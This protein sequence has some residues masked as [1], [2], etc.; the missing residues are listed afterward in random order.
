M[1]PTDDDETTTP[2]PGAAPT[3]DDDFVS[4]TIHTS[5]DEDE[6]HSD[7]LAAGDVIGEY[8]VK[9][10]IGWGG[11]STVYSAV[12][13]RK[14]VRVAVKVMHPGLAQSLKQVQRF[15]QEAKALRL[16]EHPTIVEVYH[17]GCMPDGRPFIVMEFLDGVNLGTF[18]HA[19]GRFSPAEALEILAPISEALNLA[20]EAGI[21]HRDVKASNIIIVDRDNERE[22]KLLDFGIAKLV[23]VGSG[24]MQTTVGHIL[25]SPHSMAPE[26]IRG[27]RI[28]G[29]T[30][31]Y[32]LGALLYRLLTGKHPFEG[33]DALA[34]TRMHVHTPPPP[35]SQSAPV[36][37]ALDAV[38]R[39]AMEKDPDHRYDTVAAFVGALENA[40]G[41]VP[42]VAEASARAIGI[43]VDGRVEAGSEADDE[44]H[45]D[46][47]NILDIAEEAFEKHQFLI[48]LQ[49]GNAILGVLLVAQWDTEEAARGRAMDVAAELEQAMGTRPEADDRIDVNLCL[50]IADADV[51]AASDCPEVTGGPIVDV[52]AWAPQETMDGVCAT[53]ETLGFA[54]GSRDRTARS[55]VRIGSRRGSTL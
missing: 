43:Y 41:N 52:G 5:V 9:E 53:P 20:H 3:P 35:P 26:Q 30:D 32:A 34:L 6:E 40:I 4:S 14:G 38:V 37:P 19:R 17:V 55:Y 31:V 21:V 2:P 46:L 42:A 22:V 36:S 48:P 24:A 23:N 33:A 27:Q 11:C 18:I 39:R 44:L 10:E 1:P 25:G 12:H 16:I 13:R 51:R 29:R 50:H 15:V 47:M 7:S 54:A 8:V 45:D 28:D 49:T